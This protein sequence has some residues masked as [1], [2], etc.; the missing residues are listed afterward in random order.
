MRFKL[1]LFLFVLIQNFC[2]S[3]YIEVQDTFSA[4]QLVENILINS[5]CANVSNFSATGW[6]ENRSYG[7][8]SNTSEGFP[9]QEGIILSTGKAVSAEGPNN[10]LLSEGNNSWQGDADLETAIGESNSVNATVLEFDFMPIADKMIFEY[11]FSSEQYYGYNNPNQCN[12]SDGFAFLLKEVNSQENYDNLAVVPGTN[13][14]V[15]IT[16]IRGEGTI[17]PAANQ[18]FFDTFNGTEHPTNFNGQ[19]N[20]L[21][22]EANVTP[23]VLYHIKLVI[24]DQEN[25]LYDSAIFLGGG[26]FDVET[27]IG[28]D[29]L[30]ATGNPLCFGE[31]LELDASYTGNNQYQWFRN[32]SILP[33]ETNPT[34]TITQDGF[35]EVEI[36]LEN[37]N[38][39][40][41]GTISVEYEEPITLQN[42]TLIQCEEANSGYAVF[43]LYD[44]QEQIIDGNNNLQL[45]AFFTSQQNAE[46][47]TN[48]IQNPTSFA[49]TSVNQVVYARAALQ[50]GCSSIAGVTLSTTTSFYTPFELVNCSLP[51]NPSVA[52]FNLSEIIL[53]LQN[54]YGLN[55]QVSFHE[56][57]NEALEGSNELT[58]PFINTNPVMQTIYARLTENGN[59]SGIVPVYLTVIPSPQFSGPEEMTYCLNTFP[60]PI[61]LDSGVI[62]DVSDF[63]F[64]WNTG[65]FTPTVQVNEPGVYEVEV[66]YTYNYNGT[67]YTCTST[68][69]ITVIA[70]ELPNLNYELSGKYGNQ[71]VTINAEGSGNYLYALNNPD[72]PF[73]ESNVFENLS[74]GIYTVYVI[75]LNGCGV[76]SLK[77]F[78][79]GFPNYFTPNCDG[80]ND[81]WTV[82]GVNLRD[83]LIKNLVIFDRYGKILHWLD[84]SSYGWDGTNRGRPLPSSDYWFKATFEDGSIYGGHFT[85]K[86]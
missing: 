53:D 5:P 44:A 78:V 68:R 66:S 81:Y 72:G 38:C 33:G 24:A 73:Q 69:T 85:L 52:S 56:D 63:S 83:N 29:R 77:V 31:N 45:E 47:N 62:G 76:K 75:D 39:D 84:F 11:V 61:I 70:S 86:R 48:S 37:S 30:F 6:Q 19:T 67:N 4:Q 14:P 7:Y 71:T 59:C 1:P 58:S 32:G 21:R 2:F 49:N 64:R 13:I 42:I 17:C 9:F 20:V 60:E 40:I 43:N 54:E 51:N 46:N 23:G 57:L 8:F 10:S 15:K 50:T 55:L 18:Q 74:G 27:D 80:V 12:Y 36:V 41:N 65:A 26:T 79:V 28:S 25:S 3:Q 22:A 82:K 16:T 34:Y 35:Y